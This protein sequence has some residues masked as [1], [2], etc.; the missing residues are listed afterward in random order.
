MEMRS[1]HTRLYTKIGAAAAA[2]LGT[3][4][5]ALALA[6][7]PTPAPAA[8]RIAAGK[9]SYRIHCAGCHGEAGRGDG[10]MRGVLKVAPS[11]LTRLALAHGGRFPREE[12]YQVIDGRREVRG[13]G[14]AAMPVWGATFQERGSDRPQEPEVR[15][16]ILDLLAYLESIQAR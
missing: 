9:L 10:P 2:A 1:L 6:L 5:V 14:T 15:E 13:H 7:P 11:D 3:G 4:A 16:R 12:T 8:E